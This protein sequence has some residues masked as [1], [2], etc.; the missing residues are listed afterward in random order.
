MFFSLR[1]PVTLPVLLLALILTLVGCGG[2]SGTSSNT[3][4]NDT[5]ATP[6]TS[7]GVEAQLPSPP[8]ATAPS[9]PS[10]PPTTT[11]P[12]Q[13]SPPVA[14]SSET[15]YTIVAD[16]AVGGTYTLESNRVIQSKAEWD[17]FLNNVMPVRGQGF[18]QPGTPVTDD[19]DFNQHTVLVQRTYFGDCVGKLTF[20]SIAKVQDEVTTQNSTLVMTSIRQDKIEDPEYTCPTMMTAGLVIVKIP[21]STLPVRWVEERGAPF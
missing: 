17:T 4:S 3:S 21:K 18:G 12:T 8:T 5:V 1:S 20:K 2:N 7:E 14:T 15:T 16:A 13:P 10:P 11:A 19:I 6:T 9:D